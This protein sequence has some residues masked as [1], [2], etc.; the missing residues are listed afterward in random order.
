MILLEKRDLRGQFRRITSS[1]HDLAQLKSIMTGE[2]LE[3]LTAILNQNYNLAIPKQEILNPNSQAFF[4]MVDGQPV[5]SLKV[6]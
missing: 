5:A 1:Q 2:Q 4:Y 6:N 3:D